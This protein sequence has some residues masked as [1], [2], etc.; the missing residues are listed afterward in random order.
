MTYEDAIIASY[1]RADEAIRAAGRDWYPAARREVRELCARAPDGIGPVRVA[2]IVAAL[3]PRAQ[4]AVNLRWAGAI[5]DAAREGLPCPAVSL[6]HCRAKAWRIAHGASPARELRG[7]KV[8]AFWRN[9]SGD[10]SAVTVDTWAARA[11]GAEPDKLD[12]AG[13]YE[14]IAH[15]YRSAALSLGE[16]PS[17]LQAI[18][19]LEVRGVKPADPAPFR[20][21]TSVGSPA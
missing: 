3:S 20:P 15:A 19:W 21:T 12:R 16:L 9:L 17:A 2:A 10:E 5:L 13:R 14:A 4:W 11:A 18:T 8:R 1:A 7:P 6:T